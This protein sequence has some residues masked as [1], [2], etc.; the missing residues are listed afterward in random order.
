MKYS[1]WIPDQVRN[2]KRTCAGMTAACHSGE[3]QNPVRTEI[4]L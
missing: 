1:Y 3:G 4:L 2:D